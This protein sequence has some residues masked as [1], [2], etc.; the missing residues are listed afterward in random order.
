MNWVSKVLVLAGG[1]ATAVTL[2]S[3]ALGFGWLS[4]LA[5]LPT[6]IAAT[7]LVPF[8]LGVRDRRV[9]AE[10]RMREGKR[11]TLRKRRISDPASALAERAADAF[12]GTQPRAIGLGEGGPFREE[13]GLGGSKER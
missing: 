4:L 3:Y 10:R 13:N 5:S 9:A 11:R 12:G 2:A 6:F 1:L 7:I 8:F